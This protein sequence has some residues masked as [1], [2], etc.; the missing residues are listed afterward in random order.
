MHLP[1][2]FIGNPEPLIHRKGQGDWYLY[3]IPQLSSS[4]GGNHLAECLPCVAVRK[5][6]G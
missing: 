1:K 5:D 2:Y 6:R 4:L 3:L